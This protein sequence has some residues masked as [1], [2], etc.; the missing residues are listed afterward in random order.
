MISIN[1]FYQNLPARLKNVSSWLVANSDKIPVLP[2]SDQRITGN[3]SGSTLSFD[4]ALPLIESGQHDFLV[5]YHQKE[6]RIVS[7]DIDHCVDNNQRLIPWVQTFI[8]AID[9]GYYELS[10]SCTGLRI[11]CTTEQPLVFNKRIYYINPEHYKKALSGAEKFELMVHEQ[12]ATYTGNIHPDCTQ[13][14][15]LT[16]IQ[17]ALDWLN[18]HYPIPEKTCSDQPGYVGHEH[19]PTGR[20]QVIEALDWLSPDCGHDQWKKVGMALNN[21]DP[22]AQGFELWLE[23]SK[24][25]E[26]YKNENEVRV[27]WKS[28]KPTGGITIATLFHQAQANGFQFPQ[29]EWLSAAAPKPNAA[30]ATGSAAIETDSP[31]VV[32]ALEQKEKKKKKKEAR[33]RKL[34]FFPDSQALVDGYCQIQEQQPSWNYVKDAN[35]R[36]LPYSEHEDELVLWA[37][38]N[39]MPKGLYEARPLAAAYRQVQAREYR[40]LITDLA[41]TMQSEPCDPANDFH[42]LAEQL[43]L[44]YTEQLVL[45]WWLSDRKKVLLQIAQGNNPTPD[46]VPMPIFYSPIQDTGKS[47]FVSQLCRPLGELADI[48][49]VSDLSDEFAHT[50]WSKLLVANFDE[51]VGLDRTD[52][53]VFKQ[54]CYSDCYTKRKMRSEL[55]HRINKITAGI[56]SS[57]NPIAEMVNDTTGTRRLFDIQAPDDGRLIT[58]AREFDFTSLWQTL[59][60]DAHPTADELAAIR[61]V[62]DTQRRRHPVEDWFDEQGRSIL[63]VN[64]QNGGGTA[65]SALYDD[66]RK[67]AYQ[68]NEM[69][70]ERS[71]FG[72]LLNQYCKGRIK[73]VRRD[74]SYYHLIE[75]EPD[76][77]IQLTV[78]M[79]A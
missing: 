74:G 9:P 2:Q 66:Y 67:W 53:K 36:Q 6:N 29:K 35:G 1:H 21:W 46:Q 18:Q 70:F 62:Q 31:E 45:Y 54:W 65:Y 42:A 19:P 3:K 57:N 51:L 33:E 24:T 69:T 11:P 20:D 44:G 75:N 47:W 76:S 28:F 56:G 17:P 23:W 52:I 50:Q 15:Q 7:I 78:R 5:F 63:L 68:T 73:S 41:V 30:S 37:Q 58:L 49:H 77:K 72:R 40:Q 32:T 22:G 38:R 13:P 39:E 60:V 48:K 14:Q 64:G 34:S 71:H 27:A 61:A 55:M 43:Q 79:Q 10:S 8:D 59:S 25:G 16:P 26:S 12:L 4:I